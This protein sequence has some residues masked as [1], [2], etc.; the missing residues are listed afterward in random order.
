[1]RLVMAKKTHLPVQLWQWDS[2]LLNEGQLFSS[3]ASLRQKTHVPVPYNIGNNTCFLEKPVSCKN[4]TGN[5]IRLQRAITTSAACFQPPFR[6]N[7]PPKPRDFSQL[8]QRRKRY[9][10]RICRPL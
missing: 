10:R 2:A 9:S 3:A 5:S 7:R 8:L 1:M 6:R 4:H